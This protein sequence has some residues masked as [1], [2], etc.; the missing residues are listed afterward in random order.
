MTASDQPRV[1]C[2]GG[3]VHDSSGRLLLVR[4]GNAP[5]RGLWSVP[6]GRVEPGET[7]VEAVTR[8]VREETGL[9]VTVGGLAGTVLRPA[10][11]GLYEI[12]DYRCQVIG[13][14]LRAGDDAI[15]A[16]WVTAAIFTT[17]QREG[18]LTIGL[19]DALGDWDCLPRR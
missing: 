15:D 5:G 13:G 7:D 16:A 3:I 18:A 12:H 17:L 19:A 14:Q 2:V 9:S 11:R 6:G 1:R 10:P 4:R 8:E